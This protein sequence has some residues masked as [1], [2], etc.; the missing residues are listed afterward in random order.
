[1]GVVGVTRSFATQM[2]RAGYDARSVQ[3]LMGHSDIRTTMT[4]V[5]AVTDA[6]IGVES[7]LDRPA[8]RD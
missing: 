2:L 1:M 3:R 5:E 6:G 8:E 4:Y 7:P